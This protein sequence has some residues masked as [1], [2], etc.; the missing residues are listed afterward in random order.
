[1]GLAWRA[2]HTSD[3]IRNIIGRAMPTSDSSGPT[4]PPRGSK[5]EKSDVYATR[6]LMLFCVTAGYVLQH[7]IS[8]K[9]VLIAYSV[10]LSSLLSYT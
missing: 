6:Q 10:T 2:I 1:M 9:P 3:S 8:A 4:A 7:Y 5:E